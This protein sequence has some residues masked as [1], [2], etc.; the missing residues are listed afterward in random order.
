VSGLK[1]SFCPLNGAFKESS[2]V[3]FDGLTV[4][5]SDALHREDKRIE[6]D[7]RSHDRLTIERFHSM[8]SLCMY[9]RIVV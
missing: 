3:R 4:G 2:V 1:R 8:D 5:L 6:G 7:V 9:C